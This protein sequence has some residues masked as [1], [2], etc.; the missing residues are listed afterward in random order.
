MGVLKVG[1]NVFSKPEAYLWSQDQCVDIPPI[2]VCISLWNTVYIVKRMPRLNF[3]TF[4]INE[5]EKRK[6]KETSRTYHSEQNILQGIQQRYQVSVYI[7]PDGSLQG[8][9]VRTDD[10]L[11][12]LTVL[13][14]E[15][16]WHSANSILLSKIG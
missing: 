11:D 7:C 2:S 6:R 9:R 8:R 14:I 12:F 15:E 1:F 3:P 16:G 4:L 5:E 13:E 10:F